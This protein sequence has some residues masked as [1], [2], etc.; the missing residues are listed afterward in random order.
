MSNA[1][2]DVE[3]A[4]GAQFADGDS[5]PVDFGDGI[6][7]ETAARDAVA[8][9]DRSTVGW[10]DVAGRDARTF[11]H[12]LATNAFGQMEPGSGRETFLTTN[13]ARVVAHAVA[14]YFRTGDQDVIRL[15]VEDGRAGSALK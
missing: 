3:R 13:K 4:A 12:N 10:V 11:L 15:E 1:L 9:F 8:I 7:E 2:R 5:I 6:A 14:G